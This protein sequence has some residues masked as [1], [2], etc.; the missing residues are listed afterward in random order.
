M[1]GC[2]ILGGQTSPTY[3]QEVRTPQP[4]RRGRN[5]QFPGK[6]C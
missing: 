4:L 2:D 6:S 1:K 3:F 5:T